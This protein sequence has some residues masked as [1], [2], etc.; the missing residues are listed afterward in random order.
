MAMSVPLFV[1]MM[2]LSKT[3]TYQL[4][5]A[6]IFLHFKLWHLSKGHFSRTKAV[7]M[8]VSGLLGGWS[9]SCADASPLLC[10]QR[11]EVL[12]LSDARGNP[13]GH[14]RHSNKHAVTAKKPALVRWYES[15]QALTFQ[16]H[17]TER[18]SP[19]GWAGNWVV[20]CLK[21]AELQSAAL[22]T[23]S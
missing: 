23:K 3:F 18:R 5:I 12:Q 8:A 6:G 17:W 7:V 15:N 22:K 20:G 10:Q 9:W 4:N 16:R 1:I 11:S 21:W 13:A 19:A 2:L 14:A